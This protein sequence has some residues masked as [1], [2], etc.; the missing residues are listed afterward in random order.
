MKKRKVTIE[1]IRK[2]SGKEGI[3]PKLGLGDQV[4]F[5]RGS[6]LRFK[7]VIITGVRM[8][9]PPKQRKEEVSKTGLESPN[10]D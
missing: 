2:V 9:T 5:P 6:I 3:T 1:I 8:Y 4:L 7:A 10:K